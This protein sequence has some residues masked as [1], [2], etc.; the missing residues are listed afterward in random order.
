VAR[1]FP[2]ASVSPPT[3]QIEFHYMHLGAEQFTPFAEIFLAFSSG[4]FVDGRQ[5]FDG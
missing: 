3:Q 4:T 2:V 1:Q 5:N